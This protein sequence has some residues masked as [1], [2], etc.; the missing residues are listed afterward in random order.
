MRTIRGCAV[1]LIV[2]AILGAVT[3]HEA[4]P[5]SFFLLIGALV[6]ALLVTIEFGV[7]W[8]GG[9]DAD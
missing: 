5:S 7:R 4:G 9:G 8:I 6:F 1:A 3:N 2:V